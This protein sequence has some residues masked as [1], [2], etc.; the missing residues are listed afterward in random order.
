MSLWDTIK[1]VGGDIAHAGG[2]FINGVESFAPAFLNSAESFGSTVANDFNATKNF[3]AQ[4]FNLSG[5]LARVGLE[6]TWNGLE[7]AGSNVVNFAEKGFDSLTHP[8]NPNPPAAQGLEFSETK[9]ASDLAYRANQGEIYKFP[10]GENWQVADVKDDSDTSFRA[11]A[12]KS[13]DPNDHRVIVAYAGTTFTDLKDWKANLS[14]GAGLPSAQYGE[15]VDF[16]NKWKATSGNNVILTGHSLG[17]GL[18]SYAAVK[19]NLHAT[20]VNS[21]PLA[22]DHLGLNPAVA[23]RI[24]QYYV[25]GEVL[26]VENAANP[27]D[28]RPGFGIEVQGKNSFLDPRSTISNHDLSSVATNIPAPAKVN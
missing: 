26:S 28:I 10:N 5:N 3:T 8:G 25:P 7:N 13:T 12:L 16:A 24:T 1:N 21:A 19:T 17:G 20:A 11:I 22:L 6:K 23:L 27:L 2:G 18:A 15:A 14:Q 4:S 9:S